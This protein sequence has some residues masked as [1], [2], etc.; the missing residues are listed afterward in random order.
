M[1]SDCSKYCYSFEKKNKMMLEDSS[2]LKINYNSFQPMNERT[3]SM[4]VED[5]YES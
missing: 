5:A 1:G 2:E 4:V 3:L